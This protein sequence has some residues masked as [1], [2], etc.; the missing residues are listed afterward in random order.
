M[1]TMVI[2]FIVILGVLGYTWI[3]YP[4]IMMLI[5]RRKAK[6]HVTPGRDETLPGVVVVFSA[7]NEEK[8]IG[9]RISNLLALDYPRDRLQIHVGTDGCTDRTESIAQ[10]WAETDP[11]I[12]VTSREQCAGKTSM[13][14]LLES[15]ARSR[16]SEFRLL[17]P[18]SRLLV[19]T[20]ANTLFEPDALRRLVVPFSDPKIGGVCG[21]L[22][23]GY[24][25]GAV[26][27]C[28]VPVIGTTKNK[29]P[30]TN[31]G[32]KGATDESTYWN[33][34]ALIKAGESRVDSCLGANGAIYAIRAELFPEGI[35]D[36]TIID[37]FVIGMKVRE[38][39]FR[40]VYEPSALAHEDLPETVGDEWKRRVRIG[41]GAYQALSLCRACLSPGYGWFALMFW[42][43]KVLRWLTPQLSLGLMMIGLGLLGEWA[44]RTEGWVV[45]LTAVGV[46]LA[47]V[48]F[49]V[50]VETTERAGKLYD[51]L[52]YFAAMQ[53][54]LFVGF[55]KFCRGNLKGTWERTGRG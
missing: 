2:A 4:G 52:V 37:D 33:L 49:M 38:Q 43:H 13:L 48:L 54:A 26:N 39:G 6:P 46:V 44:W 3:F 30:M 20:D 41:S 45:N 12:H 35:P 9:A 40:M 29:E 23:L 15:E 47:F 42:S 24:A 11:R 17:A 7:H 5:G 25:S 55:L 50:L 28:S 51:R 36:N 32:A 22:L 1:A 27:G 14:K 34:E 8:V 21:R 16:D 53:A 19:F 31:N 18:G 10:A